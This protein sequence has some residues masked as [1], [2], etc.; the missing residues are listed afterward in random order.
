MNVSDV[1]E[2]RRAYRSLSH[3][4]ITEELIRDLAYHAGLA[5]SCFNNQPWRFIFVYN[6]RILKKMHDALSSGNEWAKTSSLMIVVYSQKDSDCL[7]HEREYYLFDTGIAT[8]FLI[9]RATEL[10]LIAHPIAVYSPRKVKA[11]LGIPDGKMVIALVIVGQ[12]ANKNN[13]T[14][15]DKQREAEEKRPR[16][17]AFGDIA[18][19][20]KYELG[21]HG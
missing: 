8:A 19:I 11:I 1:I 12:H 2:K 14:L 4:N 15:S 3:V 16:R 5:P 9:L 7:I 13:P 18:R 20:N 10:G 21:N 17:K 6:Q